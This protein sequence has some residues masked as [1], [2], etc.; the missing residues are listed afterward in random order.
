MSTH[1][2]AMSLY[3]ATPADAARPSL[4]SRIGARLRSGLRRWQYHQMLSVMRSLT[5]EQLEQLGI[6][7]A[8]IRER[9]WRSIYQQDS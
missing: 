7:R 9:A 8:Q 6:T 2:P 1:T 4:P 3:E 5:D